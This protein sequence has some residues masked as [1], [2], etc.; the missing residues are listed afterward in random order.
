[1][2]FHR[3]KELFAGIQERLT[4]LFPAEKGSCEGMNYGYKGNGIL[5]YL[6]VDV[7]GMSFWQCNPCG[8]G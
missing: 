3:R 1:L 4:A 8:C 7:E 2:T 6:I 5:S